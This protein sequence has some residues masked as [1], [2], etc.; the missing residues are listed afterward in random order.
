MAVK[1][2]LTKLGKR[3]DPKYRIV[4]VE[5]GKKRDGEY[6]EKVGFY[7]PVPNPHVLQVDEKKLKEWLKKGAQFSEG[8]YKLL[9]KYSL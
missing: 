1:I 5:E 3:S 2:R 9:K 8:A 6:I 7:D 4:V